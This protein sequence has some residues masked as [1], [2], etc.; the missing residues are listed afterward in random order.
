MFCSHA[1]G[2]ISPKKGLLRQAL[3]LPPD[4]EKIDGICYHFFINPIIRPS[5]EVK[6]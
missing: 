4:I 6:I 2:A 3:F 5:I 1:D